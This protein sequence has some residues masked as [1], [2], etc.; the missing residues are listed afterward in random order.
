MTR[1][2]TRTAGRRTVSMPS[3]VIAEIDGRVGAREFS[4]YVTAAVRR[5]LQR[6]K[7]AEFLAT[8]DERDGPVPEAVR[9]EVEE[10]LR[11]ALGEQG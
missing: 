8:A 1:A 3:D 4:G 5:Q 7:I 11:S 10:A 9:A 6:D 2:Q